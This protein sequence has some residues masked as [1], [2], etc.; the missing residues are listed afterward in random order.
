MHYS[1]LKNYGVMFTPEPSPKA[2][3]TSFAVLPQ[4][5]GILGTPKFMVKLGNQERKW[6][7]R[8]F[9]AAVDRGIT[10]EKFISS[11]HTPLAFANALKQTC[12]R[13]KTLNIYKK[14]AEKMGVM[15]WEEQMPSPEDFLRCINPWE[16]L[17]S[18]MREVFRLWNEERVILSEVA[19][20]TEEELH[21]RV[22]D[23]AW[24]S[25]YCE[26]GFPEMGPIGGQADVTFMGQLTESLG[27]SFE[28]ECWLC[29][30]DA[31]C[32]WRFSRNGGT[33]L[34]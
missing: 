9:K 11:L 13:E 34:T 25:A 22:V 24:H 28:R 3:M 31:H 1:E 10:H 30:G 19:T 12:G 2:M 16:A 27:G 21:L 4:E 6:K 29:R 14:L 15:V 20:D 5:V 8:T 17:L 26:G 32:D 33:Q 7:K 23:C 18:Y